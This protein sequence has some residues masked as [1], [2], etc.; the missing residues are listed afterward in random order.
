METTAKIISFLHTTHPYDVLPESELAELS[1]SF[2]R[3]KFNDGEVIYAHGELLEGLYLIKEGAVEITDINGAQVS[4][5][6]KS[7]HFGERGLLRD[8]HA[9]TTATAAS[10]CTVLVLTP[11][12]FKTE[13][14]ANPAFARYFNRGQARPKVATGL[15]TQHVS[16]LMAHAPVTCLETTTISDCARMMRDHMVSS[17]AV[18]EGA[19]LTGL[20]TVRDM[21][22]KV[23]ADSL[24]TTLPVSTIMARDPITLDPGAL[25]T[26]V[27]HVMLE[28]HI[29]HLPVVEGG[30]LVGMVTQTDITRFFGSSQT[31]MVFDLSNAKTIVDMAAVTA[32]LPEFLM[33]LVGAH[34]AHDVVTRKITDIADIVTRRLL[35]MAEDE[36]G[37][38]PVPY[39]WAACGSQ[40]RREQTGVSDQ[41]NCLIIDNAATETD[42]AY[43]R[44]L[45]KFTCDGLNACGYVYCPG[46]MMAITDRW[47]QKLSVWEGY[48][49][50]W[51]SAPDTEAQMLASVM[52]DLRPISGDH[53]LFIPLQD[54]ALK[55]AAKNSIFVA[56]MIA[57][58]LKHT[59]PLG[60]LRGFA[61]IKSGE[62]RNALD[63]KHN[64]VVPIVD[65]GR[66]YA[67]Q[68][69]FTAVN[70]RA[71]IE[72]AIEAHV[73]SESGGKDLLAAYDTIATARLEH[74]A[75]QVRDGTPPDNFMS[76]SA[77]PAF[78]RSH[79]R[80]AFVIVRTMQSSL[81][82]S[83]ARS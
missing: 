54:T 77:L 52:Y 76:P 25:G 42:M 20:V 62:H 9:A 15:M 69:T 83:A 57:N 71:R 18:T 2:S 53:S 29:G 21:T 32:R 63:M 75:A 68:G 36:F 41:D 12:A 38:A 1:T 11:E 43:F 23:L 81:G 72:A 48:F 78:E 17:V 30:T 34:L 22:N 39:L 82:S 13:V 28:N 59:P 4:L 33:Q 5:L 44:K 70:T 51:I 50:K 64:G 58:S 61:T 6:Q 35:K 45:A 73:I 56:H 7:N 8:G 80:D 66:V 37:P 31:Q 74:Q 26:D 16:D 46:D 67:L 40:G 55:A 49:N 47:C 19:R 65:L 79:L 3:K 14:A 27:I 60:L 24:D 10:E